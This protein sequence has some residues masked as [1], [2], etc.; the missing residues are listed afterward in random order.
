MS[1]YEYA[2]Y[3]FRSQ[4]TD[5]PRRRF[6]QLLGEVVYWLW[7]PFYLQLAWFLAGKPG[8]RGRLW[9]MFHTPEWQKSSFTTGITWL[10]ATFAV[11]KLVAL[12]GYGTEINVGVSLAFDVVA[13]LVHKY[14]IFDKREV[15][16]RDSYARNAAVWLVFFGVNAFLAWLVF[17]KLAEGT[18]YRRGVLGAYGLLMNPVMFAIRDKGIFSQLPLRQLI[19]TACQAHRKIGGVS[20]RGKPRPAH[21]CE[22]FFCY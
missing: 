17:H 8:I 16:V 10:I 1:S 5:L 14:W 13:Y 11:Y 12:L 4:L 3:A 20:R 6:V 2:L 21:A 9:L 7:E 22:T 15:T 18:L 19:G